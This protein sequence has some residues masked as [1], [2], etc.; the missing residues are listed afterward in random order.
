MTVLDDLTYTVCETSESSSTATRSDDEKVTQT[1]SVSYMV[2]VE[3]EPVDPADPADPILPHTVSTDL[4]RTCPELPLVNGSTYNYGGTKN[5]YL[6]CSG[7]TVTRDPD[8]RLKFDVTC[9]FSTQAPSDSEQGDEDSQDP[10]DLDDITPTVSV[11]I[12]YIEK[13]IYTDMDGNQCFR[14]PSETPYPSPVMQKVPTLTL[15][16]TQYE[17]SITF[18]TMLARSY[19]LN[20]DNYRTAGPHMWMTQAVKASTV[21]V[22]LAGGPQTAAKVTYTLVYS[23]ASFITTVTGEPNAADGEPAIAAGTEYFYGHSVT[24]PLVD[25]F[26]F[27]QLPDTSEYGREPITDDE[28]DEPT[29]GYIYSKAD[30]YGQ[31]RHPDP[32]NTGV[33]GEGEDRPSYVVHRT[34][35]AISFSFLQV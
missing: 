22:E 31:Q 26:A 24:K 1:A 17:P 8:N 3:A 10:V 6:I 32:N 34:Q 35:E 15:V 18:A 13:P 21:E 30:K 12:G 28:T 33:A 14:L 27:K 23:D 5:P 9:E 25:A 4:I 7:K 20:S 16:I 2:I 11:T 19:K 29:T